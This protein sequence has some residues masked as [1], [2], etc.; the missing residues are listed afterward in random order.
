MAQ[1][2]SNKQ[3]LTTAAL[4]VAFLGIFGPT[5]WAQSAPNLA[6]EPPEFVTSRLTKDQ[7]HALRQG[8]FVLYMRHGTTDSS[9]P[10]QPGLDINNCSTQRPL[11][12]E[13]RKVARQVGA[14]I[15]KLRIPVGEVRA[16]PLCRTRETAQLAFGD[17]VTADPLLIYTSHLTS[18]QKQPIIE[19]TRKQLSEPVP[20]GTNRVLVAHGPNLADVMGYFVKPEGTV[21]VLQPRGQNKFDYLATVTPDQWAELR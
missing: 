13:G 5:C 8:G 15:K 21:V 20:Q 10:D 2:H 17:K 14:A 12:D 11:S 4:V 19:N 7:L 1:Q 16:S 3:T 6:A 9:Q 18:V